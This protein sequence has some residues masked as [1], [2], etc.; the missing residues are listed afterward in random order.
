ML[1]DSQADADLIANAL[2]Q[3]QLNAQL[4]RVET[5]EDFERALEQDRPDVIISDHGL[6]AFDSL[7][8][9]AVA[10]AKAPGLPFILVTGAPD[11]PMV[12]E[13]LHR[14]ATEYVS[15]NELP[16]LVTQVKLAAHLG[17]LEAERDR[18]KRQLAE[19]EKQAE[20]QIRRVNAELGARVA[21]RTRDLQAAN[22]ELEAF[23]YSISH[24]LRA[25]L[26]HINAFI[27]LLGRALGH[28]IPAEAHQYLQTVADSASQM[29]RLVDDLLS[30]SRTGRQE[31]RR[32]PVRLADL[33]QEAL[34]HLQ[35]EIE[36]R[37]IEWKLGD[38]PPAHGDPFS[39]RQVFINLLSNA[40]KYTGSRSPARI[41]IGCE[42]TP[43]EVV[44]HVRD[45][46]AGFDMQYAHKLFGV[47][48]RLHSPAE[49]EG[50]GIG[51]AIVR[52]VIRRHGG[53]TWAEGLVDRGAVFYFSLPKAIP[54]TQAAHE[55]TMGA[56][57]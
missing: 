28:D 25:P 27:E 41:E 53:R 3:D 6:P 37:E 29:G 35:S 47:F 49:F 56:A 17:E 14:G 39:L 11:N 20:E 16:H 44:C 45:N 23:S 1:E 36:G 31:M 5:R 50:T 2:R 32:V 22:K 13:A 10:Q 38:F 15:K 7:S 48:Q 43:T 9:L 52:R 34:L 24:D 54:E 12:R 8:A 46:G 42:D 19:K 57:G 33:V 4:K 40:L 26:R 21:E 18:L 30:F 51:L 55:G